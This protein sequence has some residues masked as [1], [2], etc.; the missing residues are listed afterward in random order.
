MLHEG[1]LVTG[2]AEVS[3]KRRFFVEAE[4]SSL[5]PGRANQQPSPT[6]E[7]AVSHLE[8]SHSREADCV[9]HQITP[10][11]GFGFSLRFRPVES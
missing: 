6:A 7:P 5:L 11:L 1:H 9:A 4:A 2:T 3:W 8:R 10:W